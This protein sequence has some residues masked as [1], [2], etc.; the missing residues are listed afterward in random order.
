[1]LKFL[2][3]Q[4]DF[5]THLALH[6]SMAPL[7]NVVASTEMNASTFFIDHLKS[8]CKTHWYLTVTETVEMSQV[9]KR[10]NCLYC[11]V[12][13]HVLVNLSD[14]EQAQNSAEGNICFKERDINI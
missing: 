13:K 8:A 2:Y 11:P 6:S 10:S 3:G 5:N 4:K 1:M 9:C 14:D 7:V 12:P